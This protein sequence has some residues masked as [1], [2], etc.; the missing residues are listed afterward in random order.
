M[1]PSQAVE[2]L[3]D[4]AKPAEQGLASPLLAVSALCGGAGSSTLAYLIARSA[5]ERSEL[6]VLLCDAGGPTGGLSIYVE[7]EAPRS[8]AAAANAL[9]D[10]EPPADGLFAEEASGLR[11]LAGAPDLETE[12]DPAGLSRL[13]GDA[14]EAHSLTVADCGTLRGRAERQVLAEAS[15]V[16]WV[17]PA[18]RSGVS[19]AR[20]V[21]ELFG[22]DR[23]RPEL[24]VAR[25][26]AGG[27]AAPVE[28]LSELAAI[29]NA[30]LVLMPHVPDLGEHGPDAALG[31]V[32]LTMEAIWTVLR[33]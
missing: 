5:S 32:G 24:L 6:P 7:A 27:R 23:E 3:P 17:M 2:P 26:D 8:L 19:R 10:P 12:A 18:T 20:R 25:H 21:L 13:L 1:T 33:R 14:R 9:V 15:H 29:R 22:L 31:E 30:A 11:V 16:A 28:E 4:R